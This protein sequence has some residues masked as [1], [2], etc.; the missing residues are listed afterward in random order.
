MKRLAVIALIAIGVALPA[1]GETLT[2]GDVIRMAKAGLSAE[3]IELKIR[4]S[5]AAFDTSTD[6]LIA[7]KEAGVS[8]ATIR[9]MIEKQKSAAPSPASPSATQPPPDAPAPQ[10]RQV[11]PAAPAAARTAPPPPNPATFPGRTVF[12]VTTRNRLTGATCSSG[13]LKI[14]KAGIAVTGCLGSNFTVTWL[15]IESVCAPSGDP[16][17]LRLTTTAGTREVSA[18]SADDRDQIFGVIARG[19]SLEARLEPCKD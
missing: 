15:Q 18:L 2:T 10:T 16:T 4:Y 11:V 12:E 13:F 17:Q 8:E 9:I 3:T 14:E 6:A 19:S 1:F 5:E 7:L